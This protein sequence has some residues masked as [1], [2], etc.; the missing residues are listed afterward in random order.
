MSSFHIKRGDIFYIH[1]EGPV[2]GSEQGADRPAIVVSNDR[3]NQ[4]SEV[5]EVVFL[6]SRAKAP[7]PTHV[8]ITSAKRVST[9]LCEQVTSVATSRLG[10]WIAQATPYEMEEVDKALLI[11]LGLD[12]FRSQS[13]KPSVDTVDIS[14]IVAERNTYKMT[15][16]DIL[17]RILK[18]N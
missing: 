4:N 9:A 17:N 5:V 18:V 7:L 12:G 1:K 13:N 3:N 8:R 14:T 10:D 2:C 16:E 15:Y 6:T 11:S